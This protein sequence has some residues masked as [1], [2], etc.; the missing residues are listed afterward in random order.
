MHSGEWVLACAEPPLPRSH[1]PVCGAI[2][3]VVNILVRVLLR[4]LIGVALELGFRR[5]ASLLGRRVARRVERLREHQRARR[6]LVEEG[7]SAE[8]VFAVKQ[9]DP[10]WPA[11]SQER[12]RV[13]ALDF[14]HYE[15]VQAPFFVRGVSIGD[16]VEVG[17]APDELVF[18]RVVRDGGHST[19]QVLVTDDFPFGIELL[20]GI[21]EGMGCV[22]R[23]A[24]IPKLVA[25]DVPPHVSLN[26]VLECLDRK[27]AKHHWLHRFADVSEIHNQQVS[28]TNARR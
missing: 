22:T 10:A 7:G 23:L 12:L 15:I 3:R 27:G 16:L 21:L 18:S 4:L 20:R 5:L 6:A 13:R 26:L 8:V 11:S 1:P 14:N 17:G 24:E 25:V 9:S 2:L 19:L 28:A